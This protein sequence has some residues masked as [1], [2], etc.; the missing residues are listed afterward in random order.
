MRFRN[1]LFPVDFSD[2]CEAVAPHVRAAC[3]RFGATLTLAHFVY[4]P[5]VGYGSIDAMITLPIA[6]I[7]QDAKERL[8]IFSKRLFPNLTVA[9]F[10]V[11]ND[12]AHGIIDLAN[13]LKIDLIM[14]PTHGRGPLRRMLLGSIAAK[15]LHDAPCAVWTAAHCESQPPAKDWQHVVFAIDTDNE[16]ARLIRIAAEMSAE[17][18]A[19]ATLVHAVP[20]PI[21]SG[22]PFA[23]HDFTEFLLQDANNTLRQMQTNA[24]TSLESCVRV[25]SVARTVSDVAA[26]RNA[27]LVVIGKGILPRFA[28]QLR[29]HAYAIVRDAPCPVLT[30]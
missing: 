29:S 12:P 30:I 5:M 7:L 28:G 16:G 3:A 15:T 4:I 10:A 18:R 11:E 17:S 9:T 23:G 1:I 24:N 8:D 6:E 19:I 2:A 27:D 21:V 25:G 13:S 26:E 22:D 14:M 20:V